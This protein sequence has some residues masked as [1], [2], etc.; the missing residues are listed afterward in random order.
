MLLIFLYLGRK[1]ID[2]VGEEG[3]PLR[4]KSSRVDYFFNTSI[5]ISACQ[6]TVSKFQDY[7][8]IEPYLRVFCLVESSHIRFFLNFLLERWYGQQSHFLDHYC[9]T[10]NEIKICY[11][12]DIFFYWPLFRHEGQASLIH[13]SV[14]CRL[15]NSTVYQR[16][17]AKVCCSFFVISRRN[18]VL[19]SK[20]YE[21]NSD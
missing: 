17:R 8:S 7:S 14:R 19:W 11:G 13:Q 20:I 15:R 4:K 9:S 21:K 10:N 2:A 16:G 3:I 12:R 1:R 18:Y 5:L 6:R